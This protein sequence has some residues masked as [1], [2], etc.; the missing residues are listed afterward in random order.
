M[1]HF[2]SYITHKMF[3][4]NWNEKLHTKCRNNTYPGGPDRFT[5]PDEKVSLKVPYPDYK[6][7]DYTEAKVFTA[8]WADK[9]E[10][11]PSIK[12]NA[13]DRINR[14]NYDGDYDVDE[15]NT[16]INPKG[17]TGII[18]RGLL[19]RFGPNHAADPVVTKWARNEDGS[20]KLDNKGIPILMFVAIKRKD[21]GQW[22]IPGGMV[23]AG[24]TVSL[25]LRKE[26]GEEALNSLEASPEEQI[27]IASN[28][29]KLFATGDEIYRGYVDDYRNTDNAWMVTTVYNFHDESGEIFNKF[30]LKAGDDAGDVSWKEIS[31]ELDLFASH[32]DFVKAVYE[33]R[34]S[35]FY[36]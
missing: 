14:L 36:L 20:I 7:V 29:E 35:K 6:P 25:T 13:L 3:R 19:G 26:F 5:V 30:K 8:P 12:F 17:R 10:T 31:Q 22:A 15:K 34:L 2:L 4:I 23:E 9:I 1:S 24:D 21:N 18:G 32:N 33:F 11:L 16:P 27:E 28:L